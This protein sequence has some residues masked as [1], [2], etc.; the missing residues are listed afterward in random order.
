M[1]IACKK[2]WSGKSAVSCHFIDCVEALSDMMS[3]KLLSYYPV[4][5]V[6]RPLLRHD[7][8]TADWTTHLVS[9]LAQKQSSRDVN[10]ECT[11]VTGAVQERQ[12]AYI[13]HFYLWRFVSSI[14]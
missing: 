4:V 8:A 11:V 13:Q 10:Y 6:I 9:K 7:K 2:I 14:D 12:H 1:I 3:F 5:F